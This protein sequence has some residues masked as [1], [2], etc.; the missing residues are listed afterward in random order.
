MANDNHVTELI[1]QEIDGANS[2]AESAKLKEILMK[3]AE[4]RGLYNDLA[5]ASNLLST[6]EEV[7]APR[8]LRANVMN[9]IDPNRY[10]GRER[11]SRLRSLV[12]LLPQPLPFRYAIVFSSGLVVGL[13]LYAL[14]AG[15][16]KDGSVDVSNLYGTMRLERASEIF[17]PAD[18]AE[19]KLDA[20]HGTITTR[21]ARGLVS[22][23]VDLQSQQ[24]IETV[25]QFDPRALSFIG[26]QQLDNTSGGI[27]IGENSLRLK[28][29][30]D[31]KYLFF[32]TD[33]AQS[34]TSVDLKI[35]SSGTVLYEK[36]LST[37]RKG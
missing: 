21:Y 32:F 18:N 1:N 23:E 22:V 10:A 35:L 33:R 29:N 13:G 20:V 28:N 7:E 34:L 14:I 31:R 19:I 16:N 36:A 11:K 4:A 3:D 26:L 25:F 27:N 24:E 5:R 8:N 2:D 17:E 30:G 9:S 12:S 15:T 6:T 37:R